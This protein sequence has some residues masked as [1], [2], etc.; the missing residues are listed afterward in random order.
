MMKCG[1]CRFWKKKEYHRDGDGDC[2]IGRPKVI[3]GQMVG[4]WPMTNKSAGCGEGEVF[5][6]IP[7][8][9]IDNTKKEC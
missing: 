8:S 7:N 4:V 5:S 2:C 1:D 9:P 6:G 3:D